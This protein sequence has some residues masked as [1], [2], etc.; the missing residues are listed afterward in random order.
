MAG[1]SDKKKPP[2]VQH[3]SNST[4]D[5]V[6]EY[7]ATILIASL[8]MTSGM[9]MAKALSR[10]FGAVGKNK[11]TSKMIMVALTST[12]LAALVALYFSENDSADERR[13]TEVLEG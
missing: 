7:M 10:F 11:T 2:A 3:K 12:I 8:A 1:E 4:A 5:I 9:A 13:A 6:R